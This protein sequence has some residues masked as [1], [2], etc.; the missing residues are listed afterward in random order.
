MNIYIKAQITNM[1]AMSELFKKSC[2]TA[3]T[4]DDGIVGKEEEKLLKRINKATDAFIKE[5]KKIQE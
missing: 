1:I 5:L 4:K 3:A 2:Q